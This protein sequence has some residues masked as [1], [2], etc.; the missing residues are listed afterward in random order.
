ML[1]KILGTAGT[2]ILNA[3][4]TLVILW[5]MTNYVGSKGLGTI[6]LIVLNITLLQLVFD[7]LAGNPLVYFSSRASFYQLLVPAYGWII[8]IMAIAVL[9]MWPFR[10]FTPEIYSV[11]VPPGY[12]KHIAALA[13]INGIMQTH[14][15]LLIGKSKIKE[16]NILFTLQIAITLILF[17]I[18]ALQNGSP[19]DYITGLYAGWTLSALGGFYVLVSGSKKGSVKGWREVSTKVF[20]FGRLSF[21]ANILHLGNKRF[22]FYIIKAFS[23]LSMLGIYNA[24][25]QLSEGVRIIGQSISLVQYSAISGSRDKEYARRLT[26]QLMKVSVVLTTLAMLVLILIPAEVYGLVLSNKFIHVKEIVVL[27]TPGVIALSANTIFSHYF[28]G[29]GHPEVNLHSN[30]AGFVVTLLFALLLIPVY[31]IKGAAAT[32]SLSYFTSMLYQYFVFQKQTGTRFSDWMIKKEDVR[33]FRILV[34]E[35]FKEKKG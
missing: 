15:N 34:K 23:G 21:L 24:G 10:L 35:L 25:A 22:S 30:V 13:I 28:S 5:L 2:R 14:Y 29:R 33:D 1:K 8:L 26:V 3:I 32:A 6:G 19:M 7:L 12:E 16:Y 27:L 4:F 20:R 9:L 11:V 17:T 18:L 31:H